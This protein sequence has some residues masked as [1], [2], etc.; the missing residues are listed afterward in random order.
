[1][2]PECIINHH[3]CQSLPLN[4]GFERP[5]SRV[6]G[7]PR[8][9]PPTLDVDLFHLVDLGDGLPEL[10]CES[11]ELLSAGRAEA[12]QLLLLGGEGAQHGDAVGVV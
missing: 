11:P 10:L 12:H 7:F 8:G 3:H 4:K 5:W 2:G 1:M 6:S 9:P